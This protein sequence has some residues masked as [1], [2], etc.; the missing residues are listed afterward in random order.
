MDPARRI[1]ELERERADKDAEIAA[2]QRVM[3]ADRENRSTSNGA[4]VLVQNSPSPKKK[5][6]HESDY[7]A[8][9]SRRR[10]RP[11]HFGEGPS[12][13][14]D[15]PRSSHSHAESFVAQTAKLQ[16]EHSTFASHESAKPRGKDGSNLI[17]GIA[18]LQRTQKDAELRRKNLNKRSTG[19]SGLP[20]ASTSS[21]SSRPRSSTTSDSNSSR[22]SKDEKKDS[23]SLA[24]I[25]RAQ[26]RA[27]QPAMS[28]PVAPRAL[29][30][31]P[32]AIR[33][34]TEKPDSESEEDE[35]DSD[36]ED[37]LRVGKARK[38]TTKRRK[39]WTVVEELEVG[40]VDHKFDPKDPLFEKY[41]PNSGIRLVG[42]KPRETSH[43]QLQLHLSDRYH[44]P[45]A[46]L[47]SLS[48]VGLN[49]TV[50]LDIDRD[51]IVI[52]VLAWKDETRYVS[53]PKASPSSKPSEPKKWDSVKG[54]TD[55]T[56][57]PA[58]E[59]DTAAFGKRSVGPAKRYL[60][61]SLVDLSSES[62]ASSG[63]GT[64]NL[65]LFEATAEDSRVDEDG[66]KTVS[67]RGGSGGAYEKFWKE[68][69]GAVVAI[70]NPRV[71]RPKAQPGRPNL[72]TISPESAD[73]MMV[74]GRARDLRS[75]EATRRDTGKP[76]GDWCDARVSNVCEYHTN[77]QLKHSSSRRAETYSANSSLLQN[78]TFDKKKFG[79]QFKPTASSSSKSA[80]YDPV[81]KKGLLPRN[82]TVSMREG[83]KTYVVPSLLPSTGPLSRGG[84][85]PRGGSVLTAGGLRPASILH[86]GANGGRRYIAGVQDGMTK[87]FTTD[88]VR[89]IGYD[90]TRQGDTGIVE[91]ESSR[92]Q[93][94]EAIESLKSRATAPP[95][96]APPPGPRIR[97]VVTT[98]TTSASS[99][100]ASSRDQP[101]DEDDLD[102][103][104]EA[105]PPVKAERIVEKPEREAEEDSDDDDDDDLVVLPPEVPV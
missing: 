65:M 7:A 24:E 54:T 78:G 43:E 105:R 55:P 40:P 5:R 11:P 61:F 3:A 101:V 30:V 98:T 19:F 22:R 62:A 49:N 13:F 85:P 84:G 79:A 74:I 8:D 57:I 89:K 15:S 35:E 92:I 67:Y 87:P 36:D 73:A 1:A 28:R 23:R 81:N 34:R 25:E 42:S 51:F 99:K 76:C 70:L 100:S 53:A 18:D 37:G 72:L 32:P 12:P 82:P 69:P 59:I 96:L 52:G 47:Y 33:R 88:A 103:R 46:L 16:R 83:T 75:C 58:S 56:D 102:W 31:G 17:K 80:P 91:D 66:Y 77:L 68:Q 10:P 63:T 41:E 26:A 2:L 20:T 44:L 9:S 45:P 14:D 90:P 60:R 97:S 95:S 64:V 27:A 93:R 86:S 39:D 94:L 6:Q 50:S 38:G 21:S 4:K 71:S 104:T 48:R 29:P